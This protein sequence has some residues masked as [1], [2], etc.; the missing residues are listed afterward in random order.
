[1][2]ESYTEE[3]TGQLVITSGHVVKTIN[4]KCV[5][6]LE[7]IQDGMVFALDGTNK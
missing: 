7:Y 4:V 1:V 5:S 3:Q 2:L 6:S